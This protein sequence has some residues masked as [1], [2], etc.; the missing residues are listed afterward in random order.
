MTDIASESQ[1]IQQHHHRHFSDKVV[2][3]YSGLTTALVVPVSI[4]VFFVVWSVNYLTPLYS[5]QNAQALP[6]VSDENAQTTSGQK[7]ESSLINT[8]IIVGIFVVVT[9][10]MVIL[11]K[12]RCIF[13]LYIWL[14]ISAAS[15]F[16]MMAWI[17]IDLTF[18]KFQV[19]YDF[20]TIAIFLWNFG[21]VGMVSVFYHSHIR[22]QQ[23]YLIIVSVIMAW[24]LTRMP[25][26]T[27][28][29]LLVGI[30]CWDIVAVLWS[31]GPLHA[32][33]HEAQKRNEPLPGFVYDSD[34]GAARLVEHEELPTS[35]PEETTPVAAA[36]DNDQPTLPPRTASQPS[37]PMRTSSANRAAR[38]PNAPD[39]AE[40][41]HCSAVELVQNLRSEVSTTDDES[42]VPTVVSVDA[43]VAPTIEEASPTTTTAQQEQKKVLTE[44]EAELADARNAFKLGLGD[45]VFYSLLVGRAAKFST[46]TWVVSYIA[47]IVGMLGTLLCLLFGRGRFAALPALPISIFSGVI[48][49]FLSRYTMADYCITMTL[50]GAAA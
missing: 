32:L 33:V 22:M 26:W 10:L 19:P 31:K 36:E 15:I 20:V 29:S 34:S 5:Q 9:F 3:K 16:F 23:V 41:E 48:C 37:S 25:E 18:V 46:L 13:I 12:L 28:W 35:T 50:A 2:K 24:L 14:A 49:Y 7:F 1:Y 30:A 6:L 27:T 43:M 11:Y 38:H 42:T 39:T 17:W 47:V 21:V 4:C 44:E 8:I 45:F 40:D